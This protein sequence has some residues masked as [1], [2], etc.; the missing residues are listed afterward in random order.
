MMNIP[1]KM[2]LFP[3]FKNDFG[4]VIVDPAGFFENGVR[5]VECSRLQLFNIVTTRRLFRPGNG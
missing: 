5:K 1:A 2:R 4:Q 3:V